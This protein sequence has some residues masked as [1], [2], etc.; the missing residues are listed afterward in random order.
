MAKADSHVIRVQ[1]VN[2]KSVHIVDSSSAEFG[3][4]NAA[5]ELSIPPPNQISHD[6]RAV[7]P[8]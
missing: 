7:L 5:R 1:L 8:V 4:Y 6:S 2:Q 3:N